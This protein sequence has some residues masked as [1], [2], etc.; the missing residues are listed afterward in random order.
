MITS[1][2]FASLPTVAASSRQLSLGMNSKSYSCMG[3]VGLYANLTSGGAPITNNVVA[4]EVDLQSS[5]WEPVL[6]RTLT[7]S[8][9]PPP[10]IFDNNI[11]VSITPIDI[12]AG[13]NWVPQTG[14]ERG[15]EGYFNITLVNSGQK[16]TG[17]LAWSVL[18]VASVPLGANAYGS[19]G[20]LDTF[21]PGKTTVLASS[22]IPSWAAIGTATIYVNLFTDAPQD[23]GYPIIR[24]TSST[25]QIE[26]SFGP[27]AITDG[28]I[29]RSLEHRSTST[30]TS[31][32][33]NSSY[34]VPPD[35]VFGA[36][37]AYAASADVSVAYMKFQVQATSTPPQAIFS[38][39]PST[40]YVNE[41]V[42]F[43]AS[44]SYSNNGTITNYSWNW[45]DGS[46]SSTSFPTITHVFKAQ[47]T[48]NVTLNVTDSQNLWSTS[49]EP[50]A[51]S[52]PTPP[53]ANFTFTP[54]P[55]WI[56]AITKFDASSSTLGWNG[57][58]H[59]PIA[60]YIWN[61]GD[62]TKNT[63]SN[64]VTYHKFATQGTFWTNLTVED[65]RGW[66]GT[67]I[68]PVEVNPTGTPP[69]A[70]FTYS[71][72]KPYVDGMVTF[73]A[74]GSY[75]SYPG[76]TI[77]DFKWSWGDGTPQIS[78]S[79][80]L[81]PHTFTTVGTF[82][83]TLNVT[84]SMNLT[85]GN[86][87]KQIKVSPTTPPVASFTVYPNPTWINATTKFNATTS[88]P[89]WNGTGNPPI[90]SYIW[91]FGDGTKMNT[92]SKVTYHQFKTNGNFLANLTVKD[93][94]GRISNT[95]A[96]GVTVKTFPLS[97]DV[98]VTGVGF[99]SPPPGLYLINPNYYEPYKGWAGNV[100]VTILN[101]GTTAESFNVT[102]NYSNA[103]SSGGLGTQHVTNLAS[104]NWTVLNYYWNTSLLKPTMNYTITANATSPPGEANPQQNLQYNITA[105]VKGPGDVNG[106][107]I[108]NILDISI[109]AANWLETVPP[110]NPR[111]DVNL[112]GIV[113]ILDI[114][115]VAANWLNQY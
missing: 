99:A 24:E 25:F 26:S 38:Y 55:T 49:Q 92:S 71:P 57:T 60:S 98:V 112:D 78:T 114:S 18:D 51:I 61:F 72:S 19:P 48:Y 6:L 88:T 104:L 52:G 94:N 74:S 83:V 96:I 89:G 22:S 115:L 28:S 36:Y 91:N 108:V 10:S 7:G 13:G 44:Q 15:S 110:A 54:S 73:N 79:Y 97:V 8:Q 33:Y 80:F 113:N 47:G 106:D 58:G 87:G 67:A 14:F 90:V 102:V 30:D 53:V 27:S 3:A 1:A 40:P 105:E 100:S 84:D 64:A 20:L 23:D 37:V 34:R 77:T 63:T 21:V 103:T 81:Y 2:M 11:Q 95:T 5:A 65:K 29:H 111:A 50:V 9:S 76:G 66:K 42:Y 56:K 82:T 107:G 75:S 93:N 39:S 41:T 32:L 16:V 69:K 62:G 70:I 35:P 59:P 101:N 4:V 85:S 43:D 17:M 46:K 31:G 86:T 68:Q 12:V 45:N 109:I